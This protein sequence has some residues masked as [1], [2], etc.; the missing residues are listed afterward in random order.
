[1]AH[2][3]KHQ[4]VWTHIALDGDRDGWIATERLAPLGGGRD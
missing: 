4:G 3:V 1:V 2:V